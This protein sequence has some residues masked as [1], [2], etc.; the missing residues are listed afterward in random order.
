MLSF[1]TVMVITYA[2]EGEFLQSKILFPSHEACSDALADY[3][4]H[5]YK[6]DRASMAACDMT[7]IPSKSIRPR[8]RPRTTT[9]P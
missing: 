8:A 5:I 4:E 2:L 7:D 1:Y 9:T 3:Y 6:F